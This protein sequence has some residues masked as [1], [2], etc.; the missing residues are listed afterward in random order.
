M[1]TVVSGP[2]VSGFADYSGTMETKWMQ[3]IP[4]WA[5]CNWF[6]IFFVVNVVVVIMLV[7]GVVYA[8]A[9]HKSKIFTVPHLFLA[10]VQ[11]LVAG[12]NALFYFLICDR[13][14]KPLL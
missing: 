9:N 1:N 4:N 13:S 2:V 7:G 10:I 14:L 6:Y 8:M 3:Q 12:T 11:L 5:I